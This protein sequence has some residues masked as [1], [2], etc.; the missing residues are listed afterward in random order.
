MKQFKNLW[1]KPCFYCNSQIDTIGIDRVNNNVG[2][3]KNN[4][5]P[6]CKRCNFMKKDLKISDFINQA[7][8]IADNITRRALK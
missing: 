3:I 2:Y 6:C 5:I 7:L 8:M 4:I 1:Q